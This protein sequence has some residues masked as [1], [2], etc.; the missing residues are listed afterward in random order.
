MRLPSREELLSWTLRSLEEVGARPSRRLG[1]RFLVDPLGIRLFLDH[2][3]AE[4]ALE[5]GPG[6][7]V[8]TRF[9]A[10]RLPRLIAAEID[11]RLALALK[12]EAPPNVQVV[13]SDGVELAAAAPIGVVYSNTPYNISTPLIRA[14]A[15]N[16]SVHLAIL[17]VQKEVA[18]RIVAREGEDSYGR[19][20]LLARRYFDA[21]IVG[22]LP[23]SSFYPRP[24]VAGAVVKLRRRRRWAPGDEAFEELTRCLFSGRNKRASRMAERCAGKGAPWLGEKRVRELSLA[25]VERLLEKY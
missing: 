4:E 10:P 2:V 12:G 21:E 9:L 8:I 15:S 22:I 16:N 14:I 20:T 6:L 24:K 5:I 3:P 13:L 19:L 7:G 18:E 23:S 25:E 17:G 1:Q 11:E